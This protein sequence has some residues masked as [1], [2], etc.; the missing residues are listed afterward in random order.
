M[1][2]GFFILDKNHFFEKVSNNITRIMKNICFYIF[3]II[4]SIAA[5]SWIDA[6]TEQK[7]FEI[8][9]QKKVIRLV[10]N[11]NIKELKRI[12][13]GR[14]RNIKNSRGINL[15]MAATEIADYKTCDYLIS[16]GFN[17]NEKDYDRR[18]A[19][20]YLLKADNAIFL[21]KEKSKIFVLFL[22]NDIDLDTTDLKGNSF[23]HYLLFSENDSLIRT[24]I[25]YRKRSL[26][27]YLRKN[28]YREIFELAKQQS[29]HQIKLLIEEDIISAN[30]TDTEERN[31]FFYIER[32][33]KFSR[34]FFQFLINRKV[35]IEKPDADGYPALMVH[36]R[37]AKNL[38]II[39]E[40][41]RRYSQ[42]QTLKNGHSI[43]TLSFLSGNRKII[44]SVSKIP[45]VKIP[46]TNR[47]YNDFILYYSEK[48]MIRTLKNFVLKNRTRESLFIE[49]STFQKVFLNGHFAIFKWI[50]E[51]VASNRRSLSVLTVREF[52]FS[53][54]SANRKIMFLDAIHKKN[55]SITR[56]EA[57]IQP[58]YIH[59]S[60][61]NISLL[62]WIAAKYPKMPSEHDSMGRSSLMVHIH[63]GR[64]S[65][66]D[67]LLSKGARITTRDDNRRTILMHA[68]LKPS[69]ERVIRWVIAKTLKENG[70]SDLKAYLYKKDAYGKTAFDYCEINKNFRNAALLKMLLNKQEKTN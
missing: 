59:L 58:N 68:V 46:L 41:I 42:F 10:Y 2:A 11:G 14:Y 8:K 26:K 54:F 27:R 30:I 1:C 17:V 25:R 50:T 4:A 23:W 32:D 35:S 61:P 55:I 51:N 13:A 31:L 12:P 33:T 38:F 63:S 49:T 37:H 45:K 52:L 43:H 19:A 9:F 56:N 70:S 7:N 20:Y 62:K 15:L 39:N 47:V 69:N 6:K 64:I 67:F 53:T 24:T 21:Q 34:N 66:L 28:Q 48:K 22:K 16:K 18:N 44:Q 3:L 36:I 5:F 65:I 57:K 29:F 40:M 60:P